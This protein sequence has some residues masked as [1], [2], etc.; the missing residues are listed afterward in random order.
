TAGRVSGRTGALLPVPQTLLKPV[1]FASKFIPAI[2]EKVPSLTPDR[3]REIWA[4]RWVI[5]PEPFHEATGW[6][7]RATLEDTLARTL[8]WFQREG[9][10]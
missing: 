10:V 6:R 7:D 2:G 4:N 1:A 3:A 9:L 8:A 5:D